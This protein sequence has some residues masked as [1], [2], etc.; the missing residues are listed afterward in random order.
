MN[1]EQEW[2][3]LTSHHWRIIPY[4]V[5]QYLQGQNVEALV[6]SREQFLKDIKLASSLLDSNEA[7]WLSA[8]HLNFGTSLNRSV[9]FDQRRIFFATVKS[10]LLAPLNAHRIT[11]GRG[12]DICQYTFSVPLTGQ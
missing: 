12:S 1:I 7:E 10:R 3:R 2:S 9:S 8:R 5:W 6:G 11:I 4:F